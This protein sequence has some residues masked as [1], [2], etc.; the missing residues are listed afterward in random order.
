MSDSR[1]ADTIIA[2]AKAAIAKL[3]ALDDQL[4]AEIDEIKAA[5][6]REGRPLTDAEKHRREA[7]RGDDEKIGDAVDA[8]SLMALTDLNNSS[9]V[10]QLKEKLGTINASLSDSLTRLKNIARYAAIAAQVADGLAQLAESA[11]ELAV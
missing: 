3:N 9:D 4:Q 11:T 7:I 1:S 6:A 8:L 5:A 2:T 10:T